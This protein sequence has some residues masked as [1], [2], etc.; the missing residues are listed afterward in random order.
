M[1]N[2]VSPAA[3]RG[4]HGAS[5]GPVIAVIDRPESGAPFTPAMITEPPQRRDGLRALQARR[6]A[7]ADRLQRLQRQGRSREASLTARELRAVTTRL[8][9]LGRE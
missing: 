5:P 7:L 2:A 3:A 4:R 9:E 6:E 1:T 8:M